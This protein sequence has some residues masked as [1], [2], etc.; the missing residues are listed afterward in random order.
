MI[1]L[2][3][4]ND[5]LINWW[6]TSQDSEFN[7]ELKPMVLWTNMTDSIVG[8][9]KLTSK[10]YSGALDCYTKAIELDPSN[11]IYYCNRWCD[12]IWWLTFTEPLHW[13]ISEIM[14]EPSLIAL[15]PSPS[16]LTTAR[17]TEDWGYWIPSSH[18]LM[19]C[20]L[21]YFSLGRYREAVEQYDKALQLEPNSASFKE[22]RAAAQRKISEVWD[23]HLIHISSSFSHH[24]VDWWM[25]HSR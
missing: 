14:R 17:L 24:F 18:V 20:R 6:N 7:L 8:N 4:L 11:S 12:F 5:Q 10:E 2:G 19:I 1:T 3:D 15:H 21:A 25:T 16:I 9:A 13:V 22:S 23:R